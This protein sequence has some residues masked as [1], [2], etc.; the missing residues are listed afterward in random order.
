MAPLNFVASVALTLLSLT[1]FRLKL[2]IV[3]YSITKNR[4][5][6]AKFFLTSRISVTFLT[7]SYVRMLGN[8]TGPFLRLILVGS[9]PANNLYNEKVE[10]LNVYASSESGF[11]VGIFKIDRPYETCPIGK[12]QVPT[13]VMLMKEDGSEAADGEVGELCY[14]DPFVRGYIN[15]PEEN[16]KAFVD[17]IFHSG[18]L[19]RKDPDGNYILLGRIGDMLKIN[20]NR[21]EPA[22]IEA[23]V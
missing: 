18:D 2:Y 23:A 10:I 20:G 15:L 14:E 4:V 1:V 13:K 6:L 5:A 19:A 16:S 11:A 17:G 12:P 21:I 8:K 9:E 7:P 22:E 3:P